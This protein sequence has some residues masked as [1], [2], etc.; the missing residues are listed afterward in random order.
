MLF[1]RLSNKKRIL[2]KT[3]LSIV[4]KYIRLKKTSTEHPSNAQTAKLTELG[5]LKN[6]IVE[7]IMSTYSAEGEPN[8]APMGAIMQTE[9]QLAVK[10]FN[11]SQTLRNLKA[12]KC[13]VLSLTSDIDLFYKTTFKQTNPNGTLPKS[14]FVKAAVVNAPK[15]RKAEATIE[16][17]LADL[18]SID[19]ERNQATLEVMHV[20]AEKTLP[21]AYNRAFGATIEALVHATR[22]Q[23][24]LE[25][26]EEE[27]AQHLLQVITNCQDVVNRTAPNSRYSEVMASLARLI[28]SWRKAS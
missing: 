11:S 5:F 26:M 20:D 24:Y 7:T 23:A 6:V 22:V 1:P 28:E 16:V 18:K 13:A 9:T 25:S 3:L 15:L 8:A 4:K 27:K 2:R 19:A 10:L 17:V 14:M 21:K 12:A